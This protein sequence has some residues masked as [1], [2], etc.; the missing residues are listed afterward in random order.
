MSTK[1][2]IFM[3]IVFSLIP[4]ALLLW[5]DNNVS[6]NEP[7][8]K[9]Y[10]LKDF[11]S[12]YSNRKIVLD[13]EK[14]DEQV[15]EPSLELP[16]I[17]EINMNFVG[18]CTLGSDSN[19]GYKNTFF[20]IF[21]QNDYSYFFSNMQELF[22]NDDITVANLEGT[23]TNYKVK[24]S[25]KFNFRAPPDYANIL[26]S[27]DID[28]VNIAN[29]HTKDY[30]QTGYNDTINTLNEYN[31]PFFG[32]DNYYIYEKEG[33]KIGFVGLTSIWDGTIYKRIDNAVNY[34]NENECN[35]IIFTFHWGVEREYKQNA[36]QRKVAKYAIDAGADLVVGHHP[37]V[38]QGIETYNGKYIVYSLAN[39]C[40]GGNTN[41]PDKDTMVFNM[42]FEYKDGV[43]ISARPTI[44]PAKVSSI[45]NR[46]DFKPTLATGD[47]YERI[48]KKILKNSDIK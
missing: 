15:S 10:T 2:I 39:F 35:S 29:N 36:T 13:E 28:I 31:I 41:P 18:D 17:V 20:D 7:I 6:A 30:G 22:A 37:H 3:V 19:F 5:S 8:I 21:D 34:F 32:Y 47:E 16:H 44:Y 1:E 38:L 26:L 9:D 14:I 12:E 43:L 4:V 33:I 40:F 25:K 48:M 23:F 42:I 11:V 46:N 45:K 24:V 27:G